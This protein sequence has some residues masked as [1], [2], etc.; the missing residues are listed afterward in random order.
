MSFINQW[1]EE[2]EAPS[3]WGQQTSVYDPETG[4]MV[5]G[6]ATQT[7]TYSSS[8]G[9]HATPSSSYGGY[10]KGDYRSMSSCCDGWGT[11]QYCMG[12]GGLIAFLLLA[13]GAVALGFALVNRS[14]IRTLEDDVATLMTTVDSQGAML[15]LSNTPVIISTTPAVV[16]PTSS[17]QTLGCG[18]AAC[19]VTLPTDLTPFLALPEICFYSTEAFAHT[20]TLTGGA[21]FQ[22]GGTTVAT[23]PATIG[24]SVCVKALTASVVAIKSS[25]PGVGFA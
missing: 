23:F 22:E 14:H 16:G 3:R 12:I 17:I 25:S 15:T 5:A 11:F 9:P 13:A 7:S 20:I 4:G 10:G 21:L 24:S 8:S 19:V 18:G 6:Y 1:G 2:E